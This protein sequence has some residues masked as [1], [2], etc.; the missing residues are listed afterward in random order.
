MNE[1]ERIPS[2]ARG[3]RLR[4]IQGQETTLQIPEGQIKMSGAGLEIVKLCDG[5]RSVAQ[6]IHALGERFQAPEGK[7]QTETLTFLNRLNERAVVVFK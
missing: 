6:I 4:E 1:L 5:Q 2:L 7:I 3:C